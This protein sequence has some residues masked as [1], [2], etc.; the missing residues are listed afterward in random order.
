[1]TNIYVSNKAELL[2]ALSSAKGGDTIELKSGDYGSLE[3]NNLDFNSYV[4][5]K[6]ADGNMGATF[7]DIEV[8]NSSNIRFDS[9]HIDSPSNSGLALMRIDDSQNID[10]INS[11]LNG[12]VDNVYP[13]SGPTFGVYVSSSSDGIRMENNYVH[14]VKNG[15]G[16]FGTTKP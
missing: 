8:F 9:V 5:L 3:I 13:I 2:S 1:M 15:F 7:T 6:S 10:L 12:K 11:E 14:D 16:F 4:T